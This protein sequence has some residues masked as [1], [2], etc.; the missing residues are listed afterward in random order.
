MTQMIHNMLS[1]LFVAWLMDILV[2]GWANDPATGTLAGSGLARNEA[3]PVT[4][5]EGQSQRMDTGNREAPSMRGMGAL[6]GRV[7]MGPMSPVGRS[8]DPGASTAVPGA[9]IMISSVQGQEI[10]SVVTEADGGYRLRIAPGSYRIDISP[11]A[12]GR[13]TKDVPATVT[14][15]EGQQTRLDIR[16]DTGIR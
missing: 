3:V 5:V 6:V 13:F 15:A 8:G 16:I 7:T 2:V 11:L 12:G 4:I 1:L 14:I 9:R 10:T